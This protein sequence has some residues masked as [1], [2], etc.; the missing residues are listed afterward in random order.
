MT[1]SGASL[2]GGLALLRILLNIDDEEEGGAVPAA[3]AAN[4]N[5]NTNNNGDDNDNAAL[6]GDDGGGSDEVLL[7]GSGYFGNRHNKGAVDAELVKGRKEEL[8]WLHDMVAGID[9]TYIPHMVAHRGFHSPLDR[10]DVRPLENSL[11]AYEAAWTNG[12]HLCECD[13]ALTKDERIILA[14]VDE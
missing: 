1:R 4:G 3:A 13:I 6:P 11:T 10:S 14:H 7:T 2:E 12:L 5:N 8:E 9:P